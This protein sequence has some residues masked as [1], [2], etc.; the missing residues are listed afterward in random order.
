MIVAL[1]ASA[2]FVGSPWL[3]LILAA[4]LL[5]VLARRSMMVRLGGFSGDTAGALVEMS[6][7]VM[8]AAA[9]LHL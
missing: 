6:E 4:G 5:F 3:S 9:V 8:L 1:V 2:L 7:A